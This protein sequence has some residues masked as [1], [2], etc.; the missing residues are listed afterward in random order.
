M[1]TMDE[2]N[3]QLE[4][5]LKK[6]DELKTEH[7]K[8]DVFNAF[9]ILRLNDKEVMHSRFIKSLLNPNENHGFK[10]GFL[11]LFLKRILS[12]VFMVLGF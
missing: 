4:I 10:D 11:K 1:K 3:S 2:K 5:L 9:Q 8:E 6:I 7:A 12:E